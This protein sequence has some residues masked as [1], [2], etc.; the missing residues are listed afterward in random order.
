MTSER[1]AAGSFRPRLALLLSAALLV[2]VATVMLQVNRRQASTPHWVE[3]GPDDPRVA[4]IFQ[5]LHRQGLA[6]ALDSLVRQAARDSLVLRASHQLAHALGRQAYTLS[7]GSDSIISRCSAVFGSGCYHGVVEG[8]LGGR[9]A[10][11]MST[12]ER[13]CAG[14]DTGAG[15]GSLFECVHGVGHGVLGAAGGDV[16]QALHDCNGLSVDALR[17]SCYEGVFMEAVTSVG[18]PREHASHHHGVTGDRPGAHFVVRDTDP[19]SPCREY[20]GAYG[21]ACWLFQGF[22]ILRRVHFDAGRA[23]EICDHAPAAWVP[24]CYQSV[25][26][27]LTGLFQRDDQWVI[28]RCQ[29]GRS[30]LAAQCAAGAVLAR[31]AEDWTGRRARDFCGRVPVSWR[32]ECQTIYLD[33]MTAL[34]SRSRVS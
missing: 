2:V 31:I 10:V 32:E 25:G 27:Q 29:A 8:S 7:G 19:Y 9:H 30:D 16:G 1:A 5:V 22:L 13:M 15:S 14:A 33:R 17:G 26:H 24:R 4:G 11:D 23:L 21:E 6:P 28:E 20:Q 18:A 3:I 34:R 12:L